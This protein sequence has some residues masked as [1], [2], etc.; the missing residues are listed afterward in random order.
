MTYVL[1]IEFLSTSV[2]CILLREYYFLIWRESF[3]DSKL[4]RLDIF[5]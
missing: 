2:E 1:R 3:T 4:A 5:G